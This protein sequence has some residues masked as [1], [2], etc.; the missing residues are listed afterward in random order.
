MGHTSN[1][2]TLV[3]GQKMTPGKNPKA[4]IQKVL[5]FS[6]KDLMGDGFSSVSCCFNVSVIIPPFLHSRLL[7][8]AGKMGTSKAAGP[9][10]F[11]LL[12]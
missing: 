8:E 9:R 5:G 4:F 2:E 1:P 6:V 12:H 3:S 7:S 11:L 10:R